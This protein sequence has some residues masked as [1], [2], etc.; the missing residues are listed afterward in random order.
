MN[1]LRKIR[2]L[3]GFTQ[4]ELGKAIG[5]YQSRIWQWENGFYVPKE[6]EKQALARVLNVD[7]NDIFPDTFLNR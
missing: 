3:K 7:V 2:K 5:K 1:R 4:Y 6:H